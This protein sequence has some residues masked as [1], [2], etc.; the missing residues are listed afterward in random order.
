[1]KLSSKIFYIGLSFVVLAL[2]LTLLLSNFTA[3]QQ[4]GNFINGRIC[5]EG[6]QSIRFVNDTDRLTAGFNK[7][8]HTKSHYWNAYK[9][10]PAL[11]FSIQ[12]MNRLNVVK[13]ASEM[14]GEL[15]L[16]QGDTKLF[17]AA[18]A[19][20]F[21]NNKDYWEK[22]LGFTGSTKMGQIYE[23]AYLL[24]DKKTPVEIFIKSSEEEGLV[25]LAEIKPEAQN[26]VLKKEMRVMKKRAKRAEQR[27]K[28]SNDINAGTYF[29]GSEIEAGEY[30][31]TDSYYGI[32]PHILNDL[33]KN[34][35]IDVADG[36]AKRTYI[37]VRDGQCLRFSG[38]AISAKQA[39]VYSE[40]TYET[41]MY[42]VG[43]DIAAGEYLVLEAKK[44]YT[45]KIEVF[46]DVQADAFRPAYTMYL[47]NGE[48]KKI[49]IKKGEYLKLS[50]SMIRS[51]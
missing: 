28:E 1:M 30:L 50:D 29:V 40:T 33:Q 8:S 11:V 4:N 6:N 27:S 44:S 31:I 17:P 20:G 15:I 32:T 47:E 37:K 23:Q 42:K 5:Q 45:P 46:T 13:S 3:K 34:G 24:K 38:K 39:P 18:E 12:V 14:F 48:M 26:L 9:P 7:T 10:A 21:K 49:R 19:Y 43:K 2:F 36:A 22:G 51:K 16:I 35:D 25:K 41:G